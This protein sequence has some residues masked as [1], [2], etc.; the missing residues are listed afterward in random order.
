MIMM[1]TNFPPIVDSIFSFVN[2]DIRHTLIQREPRWSP[3]SNAKGG[4]EVS[5]R[6]STQRRIESEWMGTS[7]Y[8]NCNLLLRC[9][10]LGW[11]PLRIKQL[12]ASFCV[13]VKGKSPFATVPVA[14]RGDQAVHYDHLNLGGKC[15]PGTFGHPRRSMNGSLKL[16]KRKAIGFRCCVCLSASRLERLSKSRHT[17]VKLSAGNTISLD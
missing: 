1:G 3:A 14:A 4:R 16:R 12:C 10:W 13:F 8:L 9:R 2:D 17:V 7:Y 11:I 15:N 6:C 5:L